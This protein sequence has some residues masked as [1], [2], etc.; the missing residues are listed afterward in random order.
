MTGRT[1]TERALDAFLAPQADQLPDRVLDAAFSEIARTT[2]RRALRV[3]WRFYPMNAFSRAATAVLVVALAVG[4]AVY[5]LGRTNPNGVGPAVSPSPTT[6]PP[7]PTQ[8]PPSGLAPFTSRVYG[9]TMSVPIAWGLRSASRT[10]NGTEAPV[11][12]GSNDNWG[13]SPAVDNVGGSPFSPDGATGGILIGAS[14]PV[15][16]GTTLESWTD[17]TARTTCGVPDSK[18][19]ITIDGEPATL[20]TYPACHGLFHQWVTVL[21]GGWGW[22]I[23]W[24]NNQGTE[25]ADAV[26]FEQIVAT[27]R[28]GTVP[29]ASEAPASPAPS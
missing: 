9:Y 29:A 6:A 4:G 12:P 25:T 2:Q 10:L 1:T 20:S 16:A 22:H 15:P 19:S 21:H 8:I 7:A 24:I 23:V 3:P 18:K 26:F 5:L 13:N 14:T 27:F 28:F 11:Q 17:T